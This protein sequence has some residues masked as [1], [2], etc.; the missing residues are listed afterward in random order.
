MGRIYRQLGRAN[1]TLGRL[2]FTIINSMAWIVVAEVILAR[3]IGLHVFSIARNHTLELIQDC[4]RLQ[5][6]LSSSPQPAVESLTRSVGSSL[7]ETF[8]GLSDKKLQENLQT[9]AE[10]F[11]STLLGNPRKAA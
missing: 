9:Y 4:M 2:T 1:G 8:S 11:L 3:E 6:K 5:A 10:K 7:R